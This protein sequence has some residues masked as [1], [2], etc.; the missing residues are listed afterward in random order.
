MRSWMVLAAAALIVNGGCSMY[1]IDLRPTKRELAELPIKKIKADP[2]LSGTVL[3]V[4]QYPG[5]VQE[6]LVFEGFYDQQQ[7]LANGDDGLPELRV[8]PVGYFTADSAVGSITV[9]AAETVVGFFLPR[10]EYTILCFTKTFDGGVV[11]VATIGLVAAKQ[12]FRTR[13][14]YYTT[15]GQPAE[16]FVNQV[17]FLPGFYYGVGHNVAYITIDVNILVARVLAKVSGKAL[18]N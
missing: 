12:S 17:V 7:L 18:G 8:A 13:Y 14:Y 11:N 6:C 3:F 2:I 16:K 5:L 1:R 4:N 9:T 15:L 10:N